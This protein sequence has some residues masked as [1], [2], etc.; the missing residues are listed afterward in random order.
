MKTPIKSYLG[1]APREMR[2]QK[3]TSL[4]ILAAIIL[5]TM[6]TAVIGQSAGVLAAMRQQQ[7]VTLGGN[8][9]ATF[10]QRS[11]ADVATMQQDKRLAFVG[12]YIQ[13]GTADLNRLL[14][15]TLL[16]Y[17]EDVAAIHPTKAR[18]RAGRLPQAPGEIALPADV[19]QYLGLS[20]QPGQTLHFDMAKALRHG[21]E[22]ESWQ[23][24]ADYTLVGVTETDYLGYTGGNITGLAGPGTAAMLLPA[25]YIYYNVDFRVADKAGFQSTVNALAAQLNVPELDITYNIPYLDALGIKYQTGELYENASGIV[26]AADGGFS[27]M[28]AAGVMVG[29]LLLLA[30][31]LVIYNILKI[32]VSRRIRQYGVIRAIGGQKRQLYLLICAQIMLLCAVGIPIGLLLGILSARGILTAATALLSPKIFLVQSQAELQQLIAENSNGQSLFLLISVGITLAFALL[33]ALPAAHYAANVSPTVAMAGSKV[34]IKRRRRP[35]A[36]IRSFARHYAALNL[37]RSPGRT[38]I[39]IL[40][41]VMSITVFIALQGGLT[42]LDTS[43]RL[44]EHLGDYSLVNEAVGFSPQDLADLNARPEVKSVAAV[45]LTLYDIDENA[46]PVGIDTELTLKPGET[47]QLAGLNDVYQQAFFEDTLS[48]AEMQQ[49]QAGQGCIIRNPLPLVFDGEEIPRTE[50]KAGS[51]ITI[52]GEQIP[53]LATLDGYDAYISIG[54]SGFINGVQVI[55]AP[56][57][58][59]RLTG[60][61]VWQEINPGL[62]DTADRPAFDAQLAALAQRLPGTTWL[63]YEE[64]DRQTAESFAQIRLLGWGLILFIGLIGILNIINTV[65]TNTHTRINEIG[66]QRAIGLDTGGLYQIF[67]WEGAYYGLIAAAL[68]TVSG[69]L[70]AVLVNAA[71]NGSLELIPL[72]LGSTLEAAA[73]SVLAC[74]LATL[75]PLRPISRM[76]IVSAIENSSSL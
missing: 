75:I 66:I 26:G 50:I 43:G 24:S 48:A 44:A 28:L 12:T 60:S 3:V 11:S 40:S 34:H 72:P 35:A 73:A 27:F 17:Q 21:V 63:S 45:Q 15:L 19:L 5:S 20:E 76:N 57:L 53:V 16:E 37:R 47:F 42:L 71:A 31:G 23:F 2:A 55:V 22:T 58:Y 29:L 59:T 33:A 65:Y 61:S 36:K 49:L 7:A 14:R 8:R 18:L 69:Y 67:L 41:L 9:H 25:N 52:G 13:L 68:G 46:R 6:L 51:T 54:N 62:Q 32:A 70:C 39:T 74:L 4:L 38:A 1:L 30:A 64:A 56:E 10:V